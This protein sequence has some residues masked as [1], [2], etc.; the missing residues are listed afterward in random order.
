MARTSPGGRLRTDH[1]LFNAI[2]A[3][4]VVGIVA[5]YDASYVQIAKKSVGS[6]SGDGLLYL[7]KQLIYV[8][9]GMAAMLF[10]TRFRYWRLKHF[11]IPLLATSLVLLLAVYIP[12]VGITLNGAKRWIGLGPLTFQPSE[13]AKLVVVIYIAAVLARI[14]EAQE[15]A[16]ENR[17]RS[18]ESGRRKAPGNPGELLFAPVLV[19]G[20]FALI[21]EREPDLGTAVVIGLAAVSMLFIAGARRSH[22]CGILVVGAGFVLLVTMLHG[23]RGSRL[24]GFLHPSEHAD[25]FNYQPLHSLRAVGSGG[26]T[27]MGFG[28]GR[29]KYYLPEA[30]TDYIFA[31]VAEETGLVGT[32]TVIGLFLIVSWRA[33]V[34]SG[35]TRDRF[36]SLL[37]AGI[38]AMLSWQVLINIAV[39]TNSMPATGVPLPFISFGGT[40]LIFTMAGIG[41]L[42]N[43]AQYPD[44]MRM[45][46]AV[47]PDTRSAA[48][49]AAN[50]SGAKRAA[51][52]RS[53]P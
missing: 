30:N 51:G 35:Q 28:A 17:R 9:L 50:E 14:L 53:S 41:M 12:H 8:G 26:W 39:A 4:L 10:A 20:L 46:R 22:V 1:V 49:P 29:E 11:A 6:G 18:N 21:V 43:I 24:T 5:V 3:L 13:F 16:A 31:T 7:K 19:A 44:G 40:S 42:L 38:G 36:G 25:T 37:A 47:V 27:G 33:F 45:D 15:K 32:L 2:L 23:F 34:I 52:G 48:V